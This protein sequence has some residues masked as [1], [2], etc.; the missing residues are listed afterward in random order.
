MFCKYCGKEVEQNATICV[1]CGGEVTPLAPDGT[2]PAN[3]AATP[4]QP[5]YPQQGANGYP[6]Q[7]GYYPPPYPPQPY[8]PPPKYVDPNAP[9]NGGL[10]ALSIIIPIVGIILGLVKM[11]DGEKK[12]GK[13]YL[14]AALI[15]MGVYLVFWIIY[16]MLFFGLIWGLVR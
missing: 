7:N 2:I 1:N 16:F 4:Q 9:A 12:A 5:I 3:N 8:Y 15:T 10:I 14:T 13:T 11:S 6:P